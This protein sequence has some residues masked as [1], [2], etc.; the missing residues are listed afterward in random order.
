MAS[1]NRAVVFQNVKDMRVETLDFPKL[2][3]PNGQ[4][5]PHGVI[6]K[7]VATNIC[8][9]DLH[10][11]DGFI[12]EM[13][14]GDILGYVGSTGRS[15]GPHLHYEVRV[16]GE[17]VNPIP[18]MVE[19]EAQARLALAAGLDRHVLPDRGLQAGQRMGRRDLEGWKVSHGIASASWLLATVEYSCSS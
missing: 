3:M 10:L 14:K 12:P 6:L 1:S 5:A 8:G 17:A 19:T 7:L 16:N 9:S 18:Y 4:K 13:R 15:T 2:E 11:Y